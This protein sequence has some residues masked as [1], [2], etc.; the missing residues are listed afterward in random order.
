MDVLTVEVPKEESTVKR[1]EEPIVEEEPDCLE[2]PA[3]CGEPE[4]ESTE[5]VAEEP[6]VVEGDVADGA[7]KVCDA[8]KDFARKNVESNSSEAPKTDSDKK[9]FTMVQIERQED[10]LFAFF[11]F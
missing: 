10:D 3:L 6:F 2:E 11:G 5:E 8:I 1:V 9:K 7:G 4:P